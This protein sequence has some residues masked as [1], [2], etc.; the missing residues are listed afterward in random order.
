MEFSNPLGEFG[1]LL[2]I[3][4]SLSISSESLTG[5]EGDEVEAVRSGDSDVVR[6]RDN[7]DTSI[8]ELALSF[9]GL[10]GEED[11]ADNSSLV[12]LFST[13]TQLCV[14]AGGREGRLKE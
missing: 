10:S 8:S 9:M 7:K 4:M 2:A 6:E 14:C 12:A 13:D 5:E 11:S 1:Q 3:T